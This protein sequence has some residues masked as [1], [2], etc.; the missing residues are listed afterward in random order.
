MLSHICIIYSAF[1]LT[2]RW[3]SLLFYICVIYL[4]TYLTFMWIILYF[5]KYLD[6]ISLFA[7]T[8]LCWSCL[9]LNPKYMHLYTVEYF[10]LESIS[11]SNQI[12]LKI[13]IYTN[14]HYHSLTIIDF[15]Y[16]RKLKRI[17]MSRNQHS[18]IAKRA[19]QW[20]TV[21]YTESFKWCVRQSTYVRRLKP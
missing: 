7:L 8:L 1:S 13:L 16:L 3:D 11:Q 5:N 2:F 18:T 21:L 14:Y 20:S 12:Q 4:I 6:M 19:I 9:I 10:I 17:M 15:T